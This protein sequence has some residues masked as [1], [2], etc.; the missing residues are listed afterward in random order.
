[1]ERCHLLAVALSFGCIVS[2]TIHCNGYTVCLFN[3]LLLLIN[4]ID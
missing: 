3:E 4:M 1:M 2:Q